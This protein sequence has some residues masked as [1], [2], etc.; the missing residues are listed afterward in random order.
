MKH[1]T[2]TWR[3][4]SHV[5]R[6]MCVPR[7]ATCVWKVPYISG[8]SFSNG[9]PSATVTRKRPYITQLTSCHD[10][11]L[12]LPPT[13][14]EYGLRSQGRLRL[15]QP[16][17]VLLPQ[18]QLLQ[19]G[20]D[21][22]GRGKVGLDQWRCTERVC[23]PACSAEAA[24]FRR[25][26]RVRACVR[27]RLCARLR[28]RV[29]ARREEIEGHGGI[30]F[31]LDVQPGFLLLEFSFIYISFLFSS[32]FGKSSQGP[33]TLVTGIIF[34]S[35]LPSVLVPLFLFVSRRFSKQCIRIAKGSTDSY[36]MRYTAATWRKHA[37]ASKRDHLT[38]CAS[39]KHMCNVYVLI[40]LFLGYV[41]LYT[42][43]FGTFV[44]ALLRSGI[45]FLVLLLLL[46]FFVMH[47]CD[48]FSYCWFKCQSVWLSLEQVT[49]LMP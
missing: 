24:R 45:F 11:R 27:T 7:R 23:V 8:C 36:C 18:L 14:G 48:L 31:P 2:Q 49:R 38:T 15:R 41:L 32:F 16:G 44:N 6:G 42:C 17:D 47:L 34:S 28:A 30:G 21:A 20:Q 37:L 12:S 43:H 39:C 13:P 46:L 5:P 4:T 9:A 40:P 19:E 33:V 35:I 25:W 22:R 1:F 10:P 3:G 26:F 29:R